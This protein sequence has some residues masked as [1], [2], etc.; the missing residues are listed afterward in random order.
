MKKIT[1]ALALFMTVVVLILSFGIVPGAISAKSSAKELLDY[2][3]SCIITT[4]AKEKIVKADEVYKVRSTA[5][6]SSLKGND[7]EETKAENELIDYASGKYKKE[8]FTEFYYGDAFE[9]YYWEGRSDFI[10]TFSIK[11]DIR[12]FGLDYKSSEYSKAKNGDVTLKFV[13]ILDFEGGTPNKWSYTVKIGKDNYVKSYSLS[14]TETYT[15][16]SALENKPYP[17]YHES[18]DTFTFTYNLVDVKSIELSE[19][20]VVL[21][22][23]ESCIIKASVKPDNASVKDL[24]IEYQ[25]DGYRSVATAYVDE[26][27]EIIISSRGPGKTSFTVCAYGGDATETIEVVVEYGFFDTLRY[28]FE[29]LL[30]SFLI[31]LFPVF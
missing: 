5:D 9:E 19:T 14:K 27:G 25:E 10:D 22:Y 16:Y 23:N 28:F 13:Y 3:E 30:E 6:Y 11:R 15:E 2:Y 12:R 31:I 1:K 18:H 17:V 7:L 8:T 24:Y 26:N 21:G 29:T 20:K 4:S